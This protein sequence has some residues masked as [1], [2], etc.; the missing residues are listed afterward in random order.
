MTD[1]SLLGKPADYP[2]QYSPEQLFAIERAANRVAMGLG[3]ALPFHGVDIWNA[4]E[5]TWLDAAGRP[6]VATA[7]IRVPADSPNIVE[8]K[9]LKL[10]FSSLAMTPF[11]SIEA[12]AN[13]LSTDIAACIG[14]AVELQ[15]YSPDET[16]AAATGQMPGD[17][18]DGRSVSCD[19]W[20][21]DAELLR[22]SADAFVT[23][24]L[25]SHLLHSLCPVTG[26]PDSGSVLINY[27]GPRIDRDSLLRYIVSYRQ[28]ADFHENCV[29][30]MFID[31]VEHC[32]PEQLTVYARYQRRGGID[33][34]PFRSN[35][36]T[37]APNTRLW[38]Q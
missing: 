27:H 31:L 34:N 11:A 38:Q 17:C 20:Q 37:A 7:E 35:F 6:Q 18:L 16:T 32:A 12:V 33:I 23:E 4:W 13:T 36:E 19:T 5:L 28:H 26:Q 10:Y 24:S 30:R 21:V 3:S 1:E 14:A 8:S 9:S 22:S 2:Q 29:E 25:H 15:L